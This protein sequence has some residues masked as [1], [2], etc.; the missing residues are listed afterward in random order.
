MKKNSLTL[1]AAA[2]LALALAT[3]PTPSFAQAAVT[4]TTT[5]TAAGTIDQFAP[6]SELVIR[7]EAVRE[8]AH[9][10]VTRETRF[11]DEAGA[12]VEVSRISRGVP[13]H[14][15][16]S[17]VGD[18]TV[19]SRVI[20]QK[21]ATP[22]VTE[23]HTTTT[24]TTERPLTHDEKERMEKVREAEKEHREKMR[25][26]DEERAEKLRKADKDD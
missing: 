12:P 25:E 9:Y 23:R 24:T 13:V 4:H 19:V 17:K 18:R 26:A 11:V 6:D 8:P 1:C 20:V 16:Y 3:S 14:V 15:E 21:V 22:A 5:T 2:A 10:S 7:S